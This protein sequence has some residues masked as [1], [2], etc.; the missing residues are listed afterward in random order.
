M[1]RKAVEINLTDRLVG[2]MESMLSKRK[3]EK[4]FYDRIL[5]IVR[6]AQG[7]QNK[8][9]AIELG[10]DPRK[11]GIWRNRWS[12]GTKT[13]CLTSDENGKELSD[14]LVEANIKELL[15][16]KPRSGSPGKITEEVWMR[17]QS[18]ACQSPKDYELPFTVWTHQELSTQAKRMGIS[19]SPSRYGVL[20]KKTN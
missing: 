14:S 1:G 5:I 6:S 10:C 15:S 13:L 18:L 20:L 9:I 16:D 19:I 7:M 8:S 11:V 3:L 4:H 2:I 12:E 17:L